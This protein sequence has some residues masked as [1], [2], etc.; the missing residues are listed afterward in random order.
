MKKGTISGMRVLGIF[1]FLFCLNV[2]LFAQSKSELER[3]K[4][5]LN[6]EIAATTKI[7]KETQRNKAA[8][9]SQLKTL[10][11]QIQ[12]REQL[13]GTI[14]SEINFIDKQTNQNTQT[15][16]LLEGQLTKLKKEYAGMV[17]FAFRNQSS[18]NK[19]MFV[20]A[21]K[22]FNQAY[23]RLKY[24]QQFSD[25][26]EKQAF[27]IEQT[28]GQ[29]STKVTEL[30]TKKQQKSGLLTEEQ[31]EKKTLGLEKED[32]TK[33]AV[34]LQSKEQQLKKDL[35]EKQAAQ[36]RLNRAIEDII[37]REIDLARKKAEADARAKA[38]TK[39]GVKTETKPISASSALNLTPEAA[40]LSADF[41]S[42]MGKLPWPVEKGTITEGF[43][44]HPHPILKGITTQNNGV[45]IKTNVNATVRTLF[46]GEVTGIITIPGGQIAIL[47]RHGE[48]V[49]V[50]SNL[51]SYSVKRGDKVTTK[52]A[53][54]V[55]F[56][57]TIEDQ[58]EVHLEIWKGM[59]KLDP[60][61]WL[62]K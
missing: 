53:I 22:D 33:I 61:N 20:F 41:A 16:R 35:K 26:R 49:S 8:T 17:L 21:A 18:Y 15:I 3:K 11:R 5:Q 39:P 59:T 10:N 23:K 36:A 56:T 19:L 4:Q 50:Y 31:K 14:N 40:K 29:L 42:N 9:L 12:I 48:Y 60:Q 58:T 62:F 6:S 28:Q 44:Q 34:V 45:D 38:G 24:L 2:N 30:K 7:L 51:K 47:V 55:A 1:L 27:Y 43:G 57:D 25:Y 13:I 54:G 52:Q 46:A 32:K 37:R